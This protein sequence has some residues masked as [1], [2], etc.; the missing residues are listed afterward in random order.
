MLGDVLMFL[1]TVVGV[2]CYSTVL[3]YFPCCRLREYFRPRYWPTGRQRR[4][5]LLDW[6]NAT[7]CGLFLG[8]VCL[9]VTHLLRG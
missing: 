3:W 6:L 2:A 1:L 5:N 9:L 4:S 8:N 7:G